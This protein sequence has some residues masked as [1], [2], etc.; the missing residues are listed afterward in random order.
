MGSNN[1][2]NRYN[3][4]YK[5]ETSPLNARTFVATRPLYLTLFFISRNVGE[6]GSKKNDE[7]QDDGE[8]KRDSNKKDTWPNRLV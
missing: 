1:N 4:I 7:A 2:N 6:R 8:G 5:S 3:F